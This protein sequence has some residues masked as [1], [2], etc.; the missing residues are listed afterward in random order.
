MIKSSA[1]DF[2]K[3]QE[4]LNKDSYCQRVDIEFMINLV[5]G[6]DRAKLYS[7]PPLLEENDT[8][9]LLA[10]IEKRISGVPLAYILGSKGFWNLDLKVNCNVLVPRP[11]TETLIELVLESFDER[12]IAVLDAGTG[13]GAIALALAKERELWSICALDLSPEALIVAK[14]NMIDLSLKINLIRSNWINCIKEKSF[15]L[16]ISNPPYIDK[17]DRRLKGDGIVFEPYRAL[18]SDDN[19][20]KDLFEIIRNSKSCL[21]AGGALYL[22]HSPEQSKDI[23]L[24]LEK[25]G[26]T[27]LKVLKDL[28]GD[29]RVT[30][31]IRD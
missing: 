3:E 15:D 2:L 1:L 10:M 20:Y 12:N 5:K 4:L 19:G 16:I 8:Q 24:Y 25:Y 22:E 13:S 26:Y 18:V 28:N 17:R 31:A 14:Q 29:N 7:S 30:S 27:D 9:V 6:S 23:R 11:E 21:K